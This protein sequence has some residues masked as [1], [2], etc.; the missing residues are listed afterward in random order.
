[1]GAGS[2]IYSIVGGA[3]LKDFEIRR[4]DF[5]KSNV[6]NFLGEMMIVKKAKLRKWPWLVPPK[7]TPCGALKP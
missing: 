4:F 3:N 1:M 7:P 5:G 2:S 6:G